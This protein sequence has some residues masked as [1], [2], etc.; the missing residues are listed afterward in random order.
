[1]KPRSAI[2]TCPRKGTNRLLYIGWAAGEIKSSSLKRQTLSRYDLH[3]YDRN[4]PR[5]GSSGAHRQAPPSPPPGIR[6]GAKTPR[7]SLPDFPHRDGHY[8]ARDACYAMIVPNKRAPCGAQQSKRLVRRLNNNLKA[9]HPPQNI[10]VRFWRPPSRLHGREG[11]REQFFSPGVDAMPLRYRSAARRQPSRAKARP[12][13]SDKNSS[14]VP[15][16][17]RRSSA[18]NQSQSR[19]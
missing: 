1:M 14:L 5:T 16:K 2:R 12:R 19:G 4:T 8:I 3:A 10:A 18:L 11:S 13:G 15:K 9:R 6:H 17:A 7:R